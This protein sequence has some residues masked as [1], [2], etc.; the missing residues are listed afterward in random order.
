MQYQ[1]WSTTTSATNY[2]KFIAKAGNISQPTKNEM[3]L[4]LYSWGQERNQL[5]RGE[6][7]R[8]KKILSSSIDLRFLLSFHFSHLT[9]PS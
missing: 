7:A 3:D 1:S 8:K 6:M 9:M 5:F 4:R 2:S